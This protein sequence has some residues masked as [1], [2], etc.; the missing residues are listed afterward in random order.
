[1]N[2]DCKFCTEETEDHQTGIRNGDFKIE[3]WNNA[4]QDLDDEFYLNVQHLNQNI[5]EEDFKINYC[6]MCGRKLNQKNRSK[7]CE[8]LTTGK[9][10]IN[11]IREK[12]GL[13]PLMVED[14]YKKIIIAQEYRFGKEGENSVE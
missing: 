8:E 14:A 12:N 4:S 13:E 5:Y 7:D 2:D 10:T 6:P 11:E 1:M 3:I 9:L